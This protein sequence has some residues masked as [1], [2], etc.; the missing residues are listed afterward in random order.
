[1]VGL[2][3][4]VSSTQRSAIAIHDTDDIWAV[5]LPMKFETVP[6]SAHTVYYFWAIHRAKNFLIK[7]E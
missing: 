7:D 3:H 1:V 2:R 6:A 5:E 4:F